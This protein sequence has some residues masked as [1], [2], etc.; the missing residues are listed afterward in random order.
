[1]PRITLPLLAIVLSGCSLAPDYQRP[2]SPSAE[3]YPSGPAYRG[4]PSTTALPRDWQGVFRDPV[5]RQLLDTALANN[6]DL[7]VALLNTEA[8]RAQYRI[9]RAELLPKIAANAQGTRQYL[10]RRRTGGEGVIS[11][12]QSATVGISAYELDLFGRLRSLSDQALLTYLATDEARRAAELSLISSVAGAYLT[13]RADQELL[14]L[15]RQT[16][17]ADEKSLRLTQ[18]QRRPGPLSALDQI[19]AT[20]RVDSTRAAVAR[21]T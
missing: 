11:T 9:Q 12:Q 18:R 14:A 13:W 2:P 19:Q 8:Y 10:P 4:G 20:T 1:M 7:R 5:L 21:Y 6:R 3:Q 17:Q 15:S 16:L